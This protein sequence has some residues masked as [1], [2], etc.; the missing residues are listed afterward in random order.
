[1]ADKPFASS[2]SAAPSLLRIRAGVGDEHEPSLSWK[3][4]P[5]RCLHFNT[6]P[7]VKRRVGN[8]VSFA[9]RDDKTKQAAVHVIV[10][11]ALSSEQQADLQAQLQQAVVACNDRCLY[12]AARW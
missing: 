7:H 6:L 5:R 2:G 1:M 4:G 12:F 9:T 3:L 8:R 10:S 11:M